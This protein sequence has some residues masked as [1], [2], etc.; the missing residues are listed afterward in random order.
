MTSMRMRYWPEGVEGGM[1]KVSCWWGV[2]A[3]SGKMED[4]R[5]ESGGK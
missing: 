4:G 2:S 5:W 3:W 1:V